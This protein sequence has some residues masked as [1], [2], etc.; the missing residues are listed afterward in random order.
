MSEGVQLAAT[1]S[2]LDR[3]GLAAK[4]LVEL[5]VS[6][7]P[8]ERVFERIV[9]T[10]REPHTALESGGADVVPPAESGGADAYQFADEIVPESNEIDAEVIDVVDVEVVSD[11]AGTS[12]PPDSR[13]SASVDLGAKNLG[14]LGMHG[15]VNSGLLSMQDANEAVAEMRA[16][17][18]A[19]MRDLRRR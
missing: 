2:A 6:V 9:S 1:N 15:P 14:P 18:A 3:G 5:E 7:K 16:R 19:R 10:P 12:Y 13:S 8:F 11:S 4:S 17:E